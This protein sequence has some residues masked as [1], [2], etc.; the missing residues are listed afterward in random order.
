MLRLKYCKRTRN[1]RLDYCELEVLD[2]ADSP[3]RRRSEHHCSIMYRL[4][5]Q[6]GGLDVYR[7]EIKLRSTVS[8]H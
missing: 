3:K 1:V 7:P 6:G 8:W 2:N 4:S 5:K